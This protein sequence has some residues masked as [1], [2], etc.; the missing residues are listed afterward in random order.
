MDAE[1]MAHKSVREAV[2][3]RRVA[4]NVAPERKQRFVDLLE[5][6]AIVYSDDVI[7][8]IA[9]D[10]VSAVGR[11]AR[12]IDAVKNAPS[13]HLQRLQD[14][15]RITRESFARECSEDRMQFIVNAECAGRPVRN[16]FQETAFAEFI[17]RNFEH[18]M[19]ASARDIEHV[20]VRDL[21][22]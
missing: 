18:S 6:F 17:Q 2:V 7:T 1:V 20:V 11:N 22:V 9:D 10:E 15:M 21:N 19:T 8:S 3:V 13:G 12:R 4:V 16:A 14:V 5:R